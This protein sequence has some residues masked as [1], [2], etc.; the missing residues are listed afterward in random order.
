MKSHKVFWTAFLLLAIL[1]IG[2][3]TLELTQQE[4]AGV[5]EQTSKKPQ[6]QETA[7]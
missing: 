2:G 7:R 1:G 6:E 5:T 3:C 4:E